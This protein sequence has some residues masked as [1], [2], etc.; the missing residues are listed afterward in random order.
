MPEFEKLISYLNYLGIDAKPSSFSKRKQLQKISF[1]IEELV[2]LDVGF[3]FNW[4]L[5]GP[6]CPELARKLFENEK[7]NEV[8]NVKLTE[9]EQN[10]L[11]KLKEFIGNDINS[12]DNLEILASLCFLLSAGK[13]QNKNDKEILELLKN[14]KPFISKE[15]INEYY[16]KLQSFA[17]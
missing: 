17:L 13:S 7:N 9:A 1:M 10:N 16:T 4:Y 8:R 11:L 5:H 2:G 15:K 3:K 12:S 6:Y 14:K